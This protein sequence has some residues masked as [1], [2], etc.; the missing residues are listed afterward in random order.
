M[1]Y[2]DSTATAAQNAAVTSAVSTSQAFTSMSI[3][4]LKSSDITPITV[5]VTA[6]GSNKARVA[7][8]V[9]HDSLLS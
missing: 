6:L 1:S 4:T 9:G 7:R 5:Q 8:C 3:N 2:A